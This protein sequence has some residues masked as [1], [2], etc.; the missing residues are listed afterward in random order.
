MAISPHRAY[1]APTLRQSIFSTP[2]SIQLLISCLLVLAIEAVPARC[3]TVA[4]GA[5]TDTAPRITSTQS[6]EG[7]R[8]HLNEFGVWG[9]ISFDAPTLLASRPDA[10]LGEL[11]LRYGRVLATS[12]T[13]AFEWTIDVVPVSVLSLQRLTFVSSGAGGVIVTQRRES[14]YGAGVSPIGL[15]F[16]FRRQ[17]RL[18][19]FA[20]TTGGVRYFSEDV[21]VSG[22]ARFNFTFDLS[23]GIEI[24][25]GSRRAFTIGY[26]FQHISNGNRSP[27]NPGVDVQLIYAGFSVFK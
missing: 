27:I 5:S 15:K 22:A 11:G 8:E 24:V 10:R 25:N 2:G 16:N 1:W 3:Q 23:G 7:I 9:E 12:E 19:P 20:S 14:T 18:Q 26:K 6:S 21:P 4:S 13:V 17:H